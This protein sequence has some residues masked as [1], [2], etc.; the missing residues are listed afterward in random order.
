MTTQTVSVPSVDFAGR[1]LSAAEVRRLQK[2]IYKTKYKPSNEQVENALR[3]WRPPMTSAYILFERWR[4]EIIGEGEKIVTYG[5][6]VMDVEGRPEQISKV[7]FYVRKGY[8]IL[9]WGNFHYL[10]DADKESAKKAAMYNNAWATLEEDLKR[11]AEAN[12]IRA[13]NVSLKSENDA[14][15][16]KIAEYEAKLAKGRKGE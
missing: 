2:P 1:D 15:Q 16:A 9:D 7:E 10:A 11:I 14:L 13:E 6:F 4:I 3:G 5:T 8:R 12:D